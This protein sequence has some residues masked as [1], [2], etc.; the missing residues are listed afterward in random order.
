[1]LPD[2]LVV[3]VP[4]GEGLVGAAHEAGAAAVGISDD[5]HLAV[6][7]PEG[8]IGQDPHLQLAGA[9]QLPQALRT[10]VSLRSEQ[11]GVILEEAE[12]LC[13]LDGSRVGC[14]D[15]RDAVA[16]LRASEAIGQEGGACGIRAG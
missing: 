5:P 4:A 3:E 13:L 15:S 11:R 6:H 1:M 14:L 12:L 10:V 16:A 8:L 7:Q 9:E 2:K